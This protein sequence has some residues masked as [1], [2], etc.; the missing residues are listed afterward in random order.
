MKMNVR[1][2]ALVKSEF[3]KKGMKCMILGEVGAI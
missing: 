1:S 3:G 2:I